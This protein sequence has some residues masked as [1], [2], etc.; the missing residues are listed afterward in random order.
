[1]NNNIDTLFDHCHHKL[2]ISVQFI[3][4]DNIW[5]KNQYMICD[6]GNLSEGLELN[7]KQFEVKEN[8]TLHTQDDIEYIIVKDS[9]MY[10]QLI[11]IAL[12]LNE[13]LEKLVLKI[14]KDKDKDLVFVATE[15]I[16]KYFLGMIKFDCMEPMLHDN[17]LF[18]YQRITNTSILKPNDIIIFNDS[19][20]RI[21]SINNECI[22]VKADNKP[23]DPLYHHNPVFHDKVEGLFIKKLYH[24]TDYFKVEEQ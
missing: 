7:V 3:L 17:E 6:L 1:M 10:N 8:I 24:I 12:I 21:E 5:L 2:D 9:K 14:V 16:R 20:K 18:I 22:I 11:R 13:Q 4:A 23:G 15:T 19:I